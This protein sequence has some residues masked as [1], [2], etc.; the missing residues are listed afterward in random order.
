VF[1][2][3][4]NWKEANRGAVR[5]EVRKNVVSHPHRMIWITSERVTF[6]PRRVFNQSCYVRIPISHTTPLDRASQVKDPKDVKK[7]IA[8]T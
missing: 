4:P 1:M 6:R 7:P 8:N 2:K 5:V 3:V